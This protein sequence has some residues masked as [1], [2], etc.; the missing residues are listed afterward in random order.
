MNLPSLY[1]LQGLNQI[2]FLIGH[3]RA[4]DKTSK[5]IL[6]A[7]GTFQLIIGT[8]TNFLNLPFHQLNFLEFQHGWPLYGISWITSI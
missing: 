7:H 6:I 3:L 4:R 5:L 1:T 2:K 8:T